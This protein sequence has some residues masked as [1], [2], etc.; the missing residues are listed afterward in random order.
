MEAH[1]I[2]EDD[3]PCVLIDPCPICEAEAMK[4]VRRGVGVTICVCIGCGTSIS[5]PDEAWKRRQDDP[6]LSL[7]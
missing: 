1:A 3:D 6:G 4:T 5:V 7:G 2:A